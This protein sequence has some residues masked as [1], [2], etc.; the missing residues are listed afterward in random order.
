MVKKTSFPPGFDRNAGQLLGN[1]ELTDPLF[2]MHLNPS[3]VGIEMNIMIKTIDI[4]LLADFAK[5][6]GV[7]LRT[8]LHHFL[9]GKYATGFLDTP[10][11]GVFQHAVR[12]RKRVARI[13]TFCFQRK[14][15]RRLRGFCFWV[16]EWNTEE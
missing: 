8:V 9:R 4:I 16:V 3:P 7:K 13:T 2:A 14:E 11:T 1:I 15:Q 6:I 5:N 12:F 10:S